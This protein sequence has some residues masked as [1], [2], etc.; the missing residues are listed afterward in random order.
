MDVKKILGIAKTVLVW[1]LTAAAVFMM[2]FTLFSVN[3]FDNTNSD[4]FGYKFFKFDIE[5]LY[6]QPHHIVERSVDALNGS[7]ANPL[8]DTV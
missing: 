2:V 8:L 5:A 1:L 3:T 4:L 7:I 6:G